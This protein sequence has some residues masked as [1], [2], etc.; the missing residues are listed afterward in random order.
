MIKKV[1]DY[2]ERQKS[3]RPTDCITLFVNQNGEL[4]WRKL[5]LEEELEIN[6]HPET[7]TIC[8]SCGRDRDTVKYRHYSNSVGDNRLDKSYLCGPC[9]LHE[10][11]KISFEDA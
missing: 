11:I 6:L 8:E 5:T 3:L 2:Y 7:Y 4:D 10:A 9:F 1:K